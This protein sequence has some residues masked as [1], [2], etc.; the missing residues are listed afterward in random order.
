MSLLRARRRRKK[1]WIEA[2]KGMPPGRLLLLLF[3]TGL[4]IWFLSTRF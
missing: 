2:R 4:V 1:E 3:V